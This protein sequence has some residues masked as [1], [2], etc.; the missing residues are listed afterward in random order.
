MPVFR[1]GS[2]PTFETSLDSW[3]SADED[4]TQKSVFTCRQGAA[5]LTLMM[6]DL[7]AQLNLYT[8]IDV[9]TIDD[10]CDL[11][12]IA[13]FLYYGPL[14]GILT[15]LGRK[16]ETK[17]YNKTFNGYADAMMDLIEAIGEAQKALNIFRR[18]H[19]L[20]PLESLESLESLLASRSQKMVHITPIAPI[21]LLMRI[22]AARQRWDSLE[23]LCEEYRSLKIAKSRGVRDGLPRTTFLCIGISPNGDPVYSISASADY[24]SGFKK[25]HEFVLKLRHSRRNDITKAV[26]G[27]SKDVKC[28]KKCSDVVQRRFE[29]I[30]EKNE[31]IKELANLIENPPGYFSHLHDVATPFECPSFQPKA[32]CMR[33]QVLFRYEVPDNVKEKERNASQ[34]YLG[35]TC[36]ETYAHFYCRALEGRGHAKCTRH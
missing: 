27:G 19:H 18:A 13:S 11:I 32:R 17:R 10:A 8:K 9:P 29:S 26:K 15:A 22:V 1:E 23:H 6:Y 28:I 12:T 14:Y 4:V 20:K 34:I 31:K 3:W 21:E 2:R 16:T 30:P 25:L 36:A 24:W 5:A 35:F 7:E 33:C